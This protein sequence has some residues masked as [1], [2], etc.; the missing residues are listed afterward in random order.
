MLGAVK[1]GVGWGAEADTGIQIKQSP[2]KKG[3]LYCAGI[4]ALGNGIA[5]ASVTAG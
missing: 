3:A 2:N 1:D 5:G 4:V